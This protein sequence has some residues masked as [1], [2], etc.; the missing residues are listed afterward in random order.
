MYYGSGAMDYFLD[1]WGS[2]VGLLSLIVTIIGFGVAIHRATQARKSAAAAEAASQETRDAITRVLTVVDLERAIALVQRLKVLHRDNKWDASLGHY[3]ELRAMLSD[4]DAR[5]PAPT[6]ELHTTLRE[7]IVQVRVIEDSVDGALR[8]N[9]E[10]SG[11]RN[12][13]QVLN[14]IQVHLEQI[15]SSTHF[16]RSEATT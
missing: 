14:A 12:F 3:Q 15:A 13:N 6:P 8:E 11:A 4:I 16:R 10:P 2:F 1:N 7:A 9:T 5:H